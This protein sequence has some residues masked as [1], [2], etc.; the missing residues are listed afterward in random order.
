MWVEVE[1]GRLYVESAGSGTPLLMVHG[2]PLDRRLFEPQVA[3]LADRHR[4][5][6]FDRRGFGI[7]EAAPDLFLETGD[8]AAIIE[9]LA[10]GPVHLLGMSQGARIAL[11][12]ALGRRQLVRSLILQGPAIDGYEPVEAP[13]ERIPM[14]DYASLARAGRLD[15]VRRLWLGHPMMFLDDDSRDAEQTL[16]NIMR[17]YRGADLLAAPPTPSTA[18]IATVDAVRDLTLPCLLLTG[19]HETSARRA[20][21]KKL[22]ELMPRCRQATLDKSGHLS[23]LSEPEA[24]NRHVLEFCGRVDAERGG[25]GAGALD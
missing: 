2:W 25:S 14:D 18:A 8:I 24:Y 3:G 19:A 12:F 20:H 23:N 13:G 22:L 7:S 11:R 17:D 15:E 10:L 1:G 4:V 9:A 16:G 21:A 5:V 6:A